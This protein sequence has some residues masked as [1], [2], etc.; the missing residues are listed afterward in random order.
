FYSDAEISENPTLADMT[1]AALDVLDANERGF[2]LM[3]EAGD[4]DWA[5]HDDNLDS[6]IGAV[7]SGDDA[8]RAIT[9]WA[10]RRQCWRETAVIVTADHG[11]FLVLDDPQ[12]LVAP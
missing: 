1:R 12:A 10:E 8:F 6:S 5:N 3:V 11:H 2:W 9:D 4:V 7:L